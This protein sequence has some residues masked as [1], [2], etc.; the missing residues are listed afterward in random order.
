MSVR[1]AGQAVGPRS[2]PGKG[3][4][5]TTAGLSLAW[6]RIAKSRCVGPARVVVSSLHVDVFAVSVASVM[7]DLQTKRGLLGIC[8][9][10]AIAGICAAAAEEHLVVAGSAPIQFHIPA[11]PLANALQAYGAQTGV[12]VLYESHSAAGQRSVAVEGSFTPEDALNLLLTGTDLSVRYTKPD[13]ITLARSAPEQDVPPASPLAKADLSLGTL[14]VRAG[15]E[16]EDAGP[17]RDYSES[18][19]ADIQKALQKNAKTRA[20][21]YRAVI[22][23]WI[24]PSRTVARTQLFRSTGDAER[25]AAVAAALRGVVISRA[26][27]TNMPQPVRVAIVVRPMQ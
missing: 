27:P 17:L 9:G 20:G 5:E 1:Q 10:L 8:A 3:G 18:V 12:Q 4:T 7:R 2:P 16:E 19:Q 24:D 22:D 15:G 21:S 11:Q 14:R 26:A 6:F 13:A 25:D 23:L